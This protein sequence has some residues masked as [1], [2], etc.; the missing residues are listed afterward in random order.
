MKRKNVIIGLLVIFGSFFLSS[1]FA[2][3]F[4]LPGDPRSYLFMTADRVVVV[5]DIFYVHGVLDC[6]YGMGGCEGVG[7]D[8]YYASDDGGMTW[9]KT[10]VPPAEIILAGDTK[11][12]NQKMLCDSIDS[13]LCFRILMG[14]EEVQISTNGGSSWRVEW[15]VPIGREVFMS[16]QSRLLHV[17]PDTVPYD[18]AL[19]EKGAQP[20]VVVA[21]GNQGVLLRDTAGAWNRIA[22]SNSD[23]RDDPISAPVPYRTTDFSDLVVDVVYEWLVAAFVSILFFV[24]ISLYALISFHTFLENRFQAVAFLAYVPLIGLTAFY[25]WLQTLNEAEFW[26]TIKGEW[27]DYNPQYLCGLPFVGLAL[28]WLI[29][30][31]VSKRR[32]FGFYASFTPLVSALALFV[33]PVVPFILWGIGIIPFYVIAMCLSL[34]I[35]LLIINYSFR[36]QARLIQLST[37]T[38]QQSDQRL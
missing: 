16:R 12:P 22:V 21:M 34:G 3:G 25:L 24:F 30:I 26:M 1:R 37:M 27:I 2:N 20:I 13:N 9:K 15:K 38:Q 8:L 33:G 31:L 14:K 4:P 5:Q 18:L 29:F 7:S 32:T 35:G 19:L 17:P 28:T 11:S 23:T 10:D 36:L 6:S